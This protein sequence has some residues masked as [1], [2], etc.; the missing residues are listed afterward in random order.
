M[1]CVQTLQDHVHWPHFHFTL[2][3]RCSSWQETRTFPSC[4]QSLQSYGPEGSQCHTWMFAQWLVSICVR[5]L[6]Y[7]Q[8][9]C[10]P[11]QPDTVYLRG[12]FSPSFWPWYFTHFL[13]TPVFVFCLACS[14]LSAVCCFHLR[15]I[16]LQLHSSRSHQVTSSLPSSGQAPTSAEHPELS[17]THSREW[18]S[19]PVTCVESPGNQPAR[20][21][22]QYLN[23]QHAVT[24]LWW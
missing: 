18:K 14:H 3:R 23:S 21:E 17:L 10:H 8:H 2:P 11:C 24:N 6:V 15:W 5:V 7:M 20:G 19:G 12:A 1:L 4:W 9:M 16:H 22:N 13:Q